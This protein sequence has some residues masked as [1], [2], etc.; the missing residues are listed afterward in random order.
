MSATN[1][2]VKIELMQEL[3]L[4]LNLTIVSQPRIGEGGGGVRGSHLWLE[5]TFKILVTQLVTKKGFL[6]KT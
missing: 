3:L 1:K 2:L 6:K 5:M 4:V